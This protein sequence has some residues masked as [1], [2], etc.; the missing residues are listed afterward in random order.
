[1]SQI[2]TVVRG[3]KQIE[4]LLRE[5]FGAQGRGLHEYLSDVESEIPDNIVR[6]GRYI[7][8][9][10]N[11]VIHD[12]EDIYDI[13][14]FNDAVEEVDAALKEILHKRKL[15]KERTE[16]L[17][18]STV[19]GPV[20]GVATQVVYRGGSG[21][22]KLVCALSIIAAL[23][24]VEQL[25]NQK[26]KTAESHQEVKD[27]RAKLSA[28]NSEISALKTK[29]SSESNSQSDENKE[30][31]KELRSKLNRAN[32]ELQS[33]RAQRT[34]AKQVSANDSSA[35]TN[36]AA[37]QTQPQ[38]E[39][40][41]SNSLL[42][43]AKASGNEYD[44]AKED[45]LNNFTSLVKNKT[46]I[47]LGEPDVS[48]N[49]SGTYDVRIPVS[50]SVPTKETLGILNKYF[51]DYEQ[52]PLR[53]Y[54]DRIKLKSRYAESSTAIK[55]YSG[56]LFKDLQKIGFKVVVELAGK[57]SSILIGGNARCHVSCSPAKGPSD[58]WLIQMD[59][60]P[61]ASM[62]DYNDESPIVIKG[63]TQQDLASAGKPQAYIQ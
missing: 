41:F 6:K 2:E 45:I 16:R 14:N 8:S 62:L 27:L 31:L 54:G 39:S 60:R 58:T 5:E 36:V 28:A 21:V 61:G 48:L 53:Q 33:L 18:S 47:V 44:V 32:A 42:A 37:P 10:R 17:E 55:P 15:E 4:K 56:R 38:Y 52:K 35:K 24:L 22:F 12:D 19:S 3:S 51:N 50:W 57:S 1:M 11:K 40:S 59:A 9:V 20:H 43:K 29:G 7:A 34:T 25:D 13:K 26:I 63:L 49:A 46:R 30:E 23:W